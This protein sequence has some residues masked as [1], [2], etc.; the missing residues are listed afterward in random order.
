MSQVVIFLVLIVFGETWASKFASAFFDHNQMTEVAS[1]PEF[2]IDSTKF[3]MS[4]VSSNL[5]A[6]A[7]NIRSRGFR[8]VNR[9]VYVVPDHGYDLHF[10]NTLSSLL[11]PVNEA[12]KSFISELKS[13]GV[14][15]DTV[16]IL[17]SDFGRSLTANSN[18]GTDHAWGGNYFIAGGNVKGGQI[19][20]DYPDFSLDNPSWIDRG[21]YVPT[22]SWDAV[23]NGIA[24]WFGIRDNAGLR[25]AVPNRESFEKC[26]LF[27]DSHLF[28][29]GTCTCES[30]CP[31]TPEFS[32]R[33]MP[34][35]LNSTAPLDLPIEGE[36]AA[37]VLSKDSIISPFGCYD[38]TERETS[39]AVDQTT[40]K[41]FCER[42]SL[43][44]PSGIVI[45]PPNHMMSV[46]KGI[47]I[48]A[49]NNCPKCDIISF[50][51]EGR[52]DD[53]SAW[54]LISKGDLP[55]I[56]EPMPRNAWGKDI[57]STFQNGDASLEFSS[58]EL[59][60]NHEEYLEYKLTFSAIR[61]PLSKFIQF[62][63]LEFPGMIFNPDLV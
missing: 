6:V 35:P 25:Y 3:P 45:T 36:L 24:N 50:I 63:E 53:E 51:L 33:S 39:R 13:E 46:V 29:D 38:P 61:D 2:S 42:S 9:E 8:K 62:A 54:I 52:K 12:L 26:D 5:Q 32:V 57:A 16:I 14:W 60:G 18:G 58:V 49:Q 43:N 30:G 37:T 31:D 23:W 34:F 40:E 15:D 59:L 21:R 7:K 55:W 19:L 44:E 56:N 1:I 22:T 20:G 10:G 47:R 41:F 4:Y 28:K 17:G 11:S 48:Y 27:Y